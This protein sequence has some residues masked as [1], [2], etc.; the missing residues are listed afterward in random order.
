MKST[1]KTFINTYGVNKVHYSIIV[2]GASVIRVVNFNKTFSISASDLKAAIDRQPAL[3]GGP[4][5]KGALQEAFRV[6]EETVGRPGAKKVLVV[7]TDKNSGARPNTLATA[8]RPLEDKGVLVISVGIGEAVE[9]SELNVISPNPMDVISARL[10]VN[11]SV[12]AERIMDRILKRNIPLVDVGFAIS[13]ASIDSDYIFALMK[14]II[15]TIIDRYGVLKVRFS[16][17]VYGSKVTTR[18]TFDNP[19]F[20][21]EDL[22]RAVNNTANVPGTPDLE[23][24]LKEA[25]TLFRKTSRP[26]ATKT[27][28]VLSDV[29]ARGND[30]ALIAL[31]ARLRKSGVLIL[32]VGFGAK[33]DQIGNQMSKVVITRSDYIGIPDFI[34][35][36]PVVVAETIM[37]KALQAN[38]PE[39]D[40]TFALSATSVFSKRTFNLMKSTVNRIIQ[41]YGITRIHY[42]VIVFGSSPTTHFDF[43]RTFPNKD[44][45]IRVVSNL[46]KKSGDPDLAKALESV[47][48]VYELKQVRPNAKKVVVVILD[49]KTVNTAKELNKNAVFLVDKGV[50]AI[51][52]GVGSSIDSKELQIITEEKRN[53]I[54]VGIAKDSNELAKEI[55]AIILRT[56]GYGQWAQ[57]STCSK[58]CRYLGVAGTRRRT[59]ICEIP[60]LGCDGP[61]LEVRECNTEDCQGCRERVPLNDTNYSASSAIQPARFARLDTSNPGSFRRAWCAN[62]RVAGRYLQIDLGETVEVYQVATKG[63]EESNP[64]WVTSYVLSIS[65]DGSSFVNY[66]QGGQTRVFSGNKDSSSVVFNKLNATTPIQYVRFYPIS[67]N[68][69]PCLQASVFGCSAVI[70][71]PTEGFAADDDDAG[72]GILIALWILA[73]ILTFLLLLACLYYCCWHVCCNKGKKR[74]GLAAFK[75]TSSEDGYLIEEDGNKAWRLPAAAMAPTVPRVKTPED[76]VQ[77]VSIEMTEDVKPLGVIQFG[78]ETDETKD[79]HV[80]AEEVHSETPKYSQE[81]AQIKSGAEMMT[82]SSTDTGYR[83]TERRR[84]KSETAASI[85]DAGATSAEWSYRTEQKQSSAFDNGAYMRSQEF[86][87]EQSEPSQTRAR[88]QE[89]KRSQSADEL[90][91]SNYAMFEQRRGSSQQ[92][93]RGEMGRDGYMR[94]KETSQES[95]DVTDGRFQMGTIDVAIGGIGT[96]DTRRGSSQLYGM[97]EQE[98]SFSADNGGR[99]VYY[100]DD[101]G[102]RT[103]EWYTRGGRRPGQLRNEGFREIHVE[104][105]PIYT[106]I[107][108]D[109][110]F[111]GI[112]HSRII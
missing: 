41:Q 64:S 60:E 106:E 48:K 85:G 14:R 110:E 104:H 71:P 79:K 10:N 38:I 44:D 50:L 49:K 39:I 1:I 100:L 103:E 52:V 112:R 62:P 67:F 32:S 5:L 91:T 73:G 88:R 18:F 95:V 102:Y 89:L 46:P 99:N 33:V 3:T 77:E 98:M 86:V 22:I 59:R 4:F 96:P 82:M 81:V 23:K 30:N 24:A 105:Q 76:E 26:N 101:G 16:V 6:F 65:E 74:K 94:M 58:T 2:Y 15:N 34:T 66:T 28:V 55:M 45:L 20:T 25:E 68:E 61:E 92:V 51:C 108:P 111:Q 109:S 40:L 56:S 27:F 11:P 43:S 13:A 97:E 36:R 78:I 83:S 90:S 35:E 75:D 63:Q 37:F 42:S 31:A 19:K 47:S 84:H 29:V 53:I 107:Q 8:V 87:T 9:R 93:V 21:Q 72:Q 7:I 70:I 12:L 57:W 69:Q 80:T 54:E 17:I